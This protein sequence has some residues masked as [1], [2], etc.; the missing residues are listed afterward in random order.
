MQNNAKRYS[1]RQH[2]SSRPSCYGTWHFC[3]SYRDS[4][5]QILYRIIR[6]ISAIHDIIII[7]HRSNDYV[8]SGAQR[9]QLMRAICKNRIIKAQIS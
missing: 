1:S 3:G 5:Q 4:K 7:L 6:E 2:S 9:V 8:D